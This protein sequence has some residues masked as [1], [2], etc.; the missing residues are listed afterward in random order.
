MT[1][2]LKLVAT[3]NSPVL[4]SVLLFQMKNKNYSIK[5]NKI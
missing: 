5:K 4:N 2:K 3:I 1:N